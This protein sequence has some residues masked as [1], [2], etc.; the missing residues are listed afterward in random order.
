MRHHRAVLLWVTGS[1]LLSL[2]GCAGDSMKSSSE[3]PATSPIAQAEQGKDQPPSGEIQERA[4]PRMGPGVTDSP[5]S[6]KQGGTLSLPIKP[7]VT[8]PT[9]PATPG[10]TQSQLTPNLPAGI[11]ATP[12]PPMPPT[13]PGEFMFRTVVENEYIFVFSGSLTSTS[14]RGPGGDKFL[15][16]EGPGSARAIRS[17]NGSYVFLDTT[18]SGGPFGSTLEVTPSPPQPDGKLFTFTYYF[19][20]YYVRPKLAPDLAATHV[21]RQGTST[22][23]Y[24]NDFELYQSTP[25]NGAQQFWIQKCGDLGT[26][27]E[28]ALRPFSMNYDTVNQRYS[29]SSYKTLFVSTLLR[30][31]DGSYALALQTS[32]GTRYVTAV[33]GGGYAT[34]QDSPEG[35]TLQFDRTQAQAWERFKLV[36]Q[37]N[38]T[39]SIQTVSGWFV[40]WKADTATF[41]TRVTDPRNA[42]AG[43]IASFELLPNDLDPI[44]R[45]HR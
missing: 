17:P 38:C 39:Y 18:R 16:E 12:V 42:G 6:L 35:H 13:L 27:Y 11:F 5:G 7:G 45:D 41:V 15:L 33:G 32:N 26:G 8:G 25:N 4:V 29:Y 10:T 24:Q 28:Y 44:V 14:N 31:P 20:P 19:G 1:L 37:G 23:L 36:D 9:S 40:G 2:A 30:Q 22:S 21:V 3:P 34:D 43:Y